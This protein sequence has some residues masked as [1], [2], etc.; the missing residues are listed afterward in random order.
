MLLTSYNGIVK[1]C[2]DLNATF[3]YFRITALFRGLP[4]CLLYHQ[5]GIPCIVITLQWRKHIQVL[6]L[7]WKYV[8]LLCQ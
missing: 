8:L 1:E 6:H 7:I 3:L 5:H 4:V 2:S